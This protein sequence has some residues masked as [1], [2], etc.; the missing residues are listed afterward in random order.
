MGEASA[1]HTSRIKIGLFVGA[2]VV[3]SDLS[4]S[5]RAWHQSI[6]KPCSNGSEAATEHPALAVH[7]CLEMTGVVGQTFRMSVD[8]FFNWCCLVVMAAIAGLSTF[9]LG[10][11]L[12]DGHISKTSKSGIKRVFWLAQDPVGFWSEA[13]FQLLLAGFFWWAVFWIWRA[14]IQADRP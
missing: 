13:A 12:Y 1:T 3:D 2:N 7:E 6:D 10:L 8:R 5:P 4:K 14:R 9:A 11:S